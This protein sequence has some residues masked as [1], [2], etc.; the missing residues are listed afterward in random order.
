M[1][2]HY[3]SFILLTVML[4]V[5]SYHYHCLPGKVKHTELCLKMLFV[6]QLQAVIKLCMFLLHIDQ[7]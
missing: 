7:A 2:P 1:T 4:L 6:F 3:N 5:N